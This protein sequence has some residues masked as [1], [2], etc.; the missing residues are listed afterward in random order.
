MESFRVFFLLIFLC[1]Q[2]FCFEDVPSLEKDPWTAPSLKDEGLQS[3]SLQRF[4]QL[5]KRGK[6]QQFYG[7]MGKR[8]SGHQGA[9]FI[10]LM[11]RRSSSGESTQDWD[12]SQPLPAWEP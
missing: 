4:A 1:S 8:A 11:G 12:N 3:S 6:F 9:T 2:I 10:G 7:L 5:V